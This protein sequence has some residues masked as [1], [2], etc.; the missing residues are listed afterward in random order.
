[1][2]TIK[3]LSIIFS[4][5]SLVYA[6]YRIGL[7]YFYENLN[8]EENE[9]E[10][11]PS[12]RLLL[13][14]GIFKSFGIDCEPVPYSEDTIR[15][16]CTITEFNDMLL[17]KKDINNRDMHD[18]LLANDLICTF[19]CAKFPLIKVTIEKINEEEK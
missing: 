17:N 5:V 3:K 10:A 7:R 8:D 4:I 2:K 16:L 15:I 11:P 19:E 13:V 12:S 9:I 18:E 14:A 1:M 6:L